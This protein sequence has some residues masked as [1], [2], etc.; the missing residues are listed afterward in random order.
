MTKFLRTADFDAAL[1]GVDGADSMVVCSA[2]PTTYTEATATFKLAQVAM[3]GADIV[4]GAG[5]PDGRQATMSA[6]AGVAVTATG[7]PTHVAL[8]NTGDSTIRAVTECTGPGL[9]N[10]ST[11]D[12]PSWRVVYRN[13]T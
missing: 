10:G 9:T 1:A 3:A 12:V 5:S 7:T 8:V 6:K 13:P 11:V 4:L 2:Y